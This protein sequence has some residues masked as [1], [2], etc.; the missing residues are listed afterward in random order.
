MKELTWVV[1]NLNTTKDKFTDFTYN[2][3]QN[4]ISMVKEVQFNINSKPILSNGARDSTYFNYI[5]PYQFHKV[6]PDLGINCFSS[7]LYPNN[8]EPS[9]EFLFRLGLVLTMNI[10]TYENGYIHI[11]SSC[12]NILN[13]SKGEIK[14]IYN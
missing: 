3:S 10:N 2:D 7:S 14:M 1:Y 12:Y 11:F 4:I 6:Y 13:F 5:Q 9:G 8:W